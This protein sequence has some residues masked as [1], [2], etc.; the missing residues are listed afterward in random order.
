VPWFAGS[1]TKGNGLL[2][3]LEVLRGSATDPVADLAR[4]ANEP[5]PVVFDTASL[6]L[7]TGKRRPTR[8]KL[9][10]AAEIDPAGTVAARE[11]AEWLAWRDGYG[12]R[13]HR[14]A[15]IASPSSDESDEEAPIVSRSGV[16]TASTLPPGVTGADIGTVVH[17]VMEK[18]DLAAPG[19][20]AGIARAVALAKGLPSEIVDEVAPIIENGLRSDV[21]RRACS[22]SKTWRELP[23]C[24]ARDGGTFEGKID[25]VFEEAD[26]LVIVDYK[27]NLFDDDDTSALREHYRAQAEA[28]GLAL[29]AVSDRP[30]KEVVLLFM[31][32][33][34]EEPIP[35]DADPESVERGLAALIR[36]E[37]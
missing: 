35:V 32:G 4:A 26:G 16:G 14:P 29:S 25:L 33:P 5:G 12:D 18:L 27:T 1:K 28:Y 3:Y 20:V 10:E 31:R 37:Q 34:K 30:A 17:E 7:D 21:I 23:F 13:H 15:A 22:A 2:G 19:D 6:D 8:L 36:A 11:L 24:V 9:E